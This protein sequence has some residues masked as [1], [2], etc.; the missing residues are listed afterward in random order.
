MIS[1]KI[2]NL[3]DWMNEGKIKNTK[4]HRSTSNN[5]KSITLNKI[6]NQGLFNNTKTLKGYKDLYNIFN[7][8]G[9]YDVLDYLDSV[10]EKTTSEQSSID[11]FENHLLAVAVYFDFDQ[12]W[13]NQYSLSVLPSWWWF[14]STNKKRPYRNRDLENLRYTYFRL[15][16]VSLMDN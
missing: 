4:Y 13:L 15:Y 16:I 14:N 8:M 1:N 5:G 10:W 7:N 6:V 2:N 12:S 11:N 3:T 9:P